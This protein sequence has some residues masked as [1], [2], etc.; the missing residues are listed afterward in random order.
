MIGPGTTIRGTITGDEDLQV[1]GRVEGAVRIS[2]DLDVAQSAVLEAEVEARNVR[3]AGS[4]TGNVNAGDSFVVESGATVVGDVKTPRL[5]IAEG[6]RF[7]GRIEMDFE[8]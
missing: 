5:S 3:V 2:K 7:K 6:A 1:Q 4:V 8:V